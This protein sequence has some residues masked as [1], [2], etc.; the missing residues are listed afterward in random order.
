MMIEVAT[1]CQDL[2]DKTKSKQIK[3]KKGFLAKHSSSW[4]LQWTVH[5]DKF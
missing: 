3:V 5:S 1:L 4:F 2:H